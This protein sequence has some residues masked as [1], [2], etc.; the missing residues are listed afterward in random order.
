MPTFTWWV[1]PT[2]A[3]ISRLVRRGPV[4]M[5]WP[6]I[7]TGWPGSFGKSVHL[8]PAGLY[9]LIPQKIHFAVVWNPDYRLYLGKTWCAC[10]ISFDFRETEAGILYL[11]NNKC[12][13]CDIKEPNVMISGDSDWHAP[14]LAE[15]DRSDRWCSQQFSHAL[16]GFQAGYIHPWN[17]G[18]KESKPIMS[19]LPC[20]GN[21]PIKATYNS[22]AHVYTLST[23][24]LCLCWATWNNLLQSQLITTHLWG[25]LWSSTLAWRGISRNTARESWE[26]LATCRQRQHHL[27]LEDVGVGFVAEAPFIDDI[28]IRELSCR[29][30]LSGLQPW[31]VWMQ[32]IWTIYGDVF[33]MGDSADV[34]SCPASCHPA[35]TASE[36]WCR[37]PSWSHLIISSSFGQQHTPYRHHTETEELEPVGASDFK[38]TQ[39]LQP[40]LSTSVPWRCSFWGAATD[41]H[42]SL[43]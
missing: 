31:E 30:Q 32:G 34:W 3:G 12:M 5:E 36:V 27:G 11:H 35:A 2:L 19:I 6:W 8:W 25:M 29:E 37:R 42:W 33:S 24:S 4:R 38:T 18:T 41:H 39:V 17:Q 22:T 9:I 26:H 1:S 14:N 13:H 40:L 23:C 21:E 10:S 20:A 43:D 15:T 16:P 28:W 7:S